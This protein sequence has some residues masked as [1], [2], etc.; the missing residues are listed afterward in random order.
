MQTDPSNQKKAGESPDSN[1]IQRLIEDE[2]RSGRKGREII[3]R[4]PP[5]PNGYLHIGHAKSI[6]LNFGL[7]AHYAGTCHL[8]FDDTNPS[9][10]DVEYVESIQR[11]IRWLGFD[12]GAHLYYA[13]DYYEQLY[14]L[15]VQLIRQG[16]AY[17]CELD[18]EAF[19]EYRGVPTRPGRASPWRERPLA[20]NLDL[21]A[22]MRAGEFPEGRYVLRAKIDMAS[23]NLHLRDP[24]I[25][26]IKH[27]AHHRTLT[28][29]CIYPMYDFA[30]CVSDSIEKITHSICTLE[31][32]VHRPLYDWF[33]D[34]LQVYHPQ[35]IE[36]AR[37]NLSYTIMSKRKLQVLVTGA[38]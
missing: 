9:T 24:V 20:E 17:V 26:R 5:E 6:C 10:E 37:L 38:H 25:Y 7:A 3:T 33:L 16:Q 34:A 15:A 27:V 4:F 23:P 18:A 22:R 2:R 12:W 36:F 29:W 35:Q 32:E 11:D 28:R 13:S 19:R 31:F 30:H 8:R 14:D 21:F 1:F